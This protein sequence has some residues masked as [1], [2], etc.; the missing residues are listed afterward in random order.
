[1]AFDYTPM[2]IADIVYA[3]D[4]TQQLIDD[5]VTGKRAFPA[6]GKNGIILYGTYGT[7]KTTLAKMLPDAIEVAR[8]GNPGWHRYEQIGP[9]NNGVTLFSSLQ[10]TAQNMPFGLFQTFVLD[11]ADLMTSVCM[12][13]LKGLMNYTHTL[14]IICTNNLGA[15]DPAVKNRSHVI[16]FNAA[17]ADRWMPLARRIMRDY[18][19]PNIDYAALTPVINA[20]NGSA[21][22]IM[23]DLIEFAQQTRERRGL[24]RL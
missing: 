1:M 6:Y 2:S 18:G 4:A 10:N 20:H 21:R 12:Q 3:D 16:A 9:S 17:P 14:W 7:G 11:E 8:G 23:N 13:S 19:V 15:I 22:C 5:L 24:P